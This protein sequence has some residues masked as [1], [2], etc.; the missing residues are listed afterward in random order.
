MSIFDDE[1]E[2]LRKKYEDKFKKR[3]PGI[4]YDEFDNLEQYKEYLKK[5]IEE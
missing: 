1:A 3:A 2:E 4:N 5:L